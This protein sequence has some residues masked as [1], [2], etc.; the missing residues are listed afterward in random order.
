MR[1]KIAIFVGIGLTV[2]FFSLLFV[3]EKYVQMYLGE[4]W[5]Y[6]RAVGVDFLGFNKKGELD[7]ISFVLSKNMN[8]IGVKSGDRPEEVERKFGK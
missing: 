5:R 1:R 6:N 3:C 4:I 7:F 8:I 2:I